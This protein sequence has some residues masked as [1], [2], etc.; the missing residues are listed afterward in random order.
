MV[1]AVYKYQIFTPWRGTVSGE[2]Q[3]EVVGGV[4]GEDEWFKFYEEVD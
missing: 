3:W 1:K 4:G 2:L